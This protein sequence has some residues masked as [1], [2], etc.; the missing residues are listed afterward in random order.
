MKVQ[1]H[2][3]I[4]KEDWWRVEKGKEDGMGLKIASEPE[5]L[6]QHVFLNSITVDER[7]MATALKKQFGK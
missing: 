2:L 6:E 5:T 3:V 1:D 4:L 7:Y